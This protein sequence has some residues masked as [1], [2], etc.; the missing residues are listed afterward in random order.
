M[1]LHCIDSACF[2]LLEP[3]KE[4]VVRLGDLVSPHSGS[5][6]KKR[7]GASFPLKDKEEEGPTQEERQVRDAVGP[8]NFTD[9]DLNHS[10][11]PPPGRRFAQRFWWKTEF[12]LWMG[13]GMCSG[14]TLGFCMKSA[15]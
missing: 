12:L 14:S 8:F 11:T 4:D 1:G 5:K 6:R 15:A 7:P 13:A 2:S 9:V 3:V 10:S